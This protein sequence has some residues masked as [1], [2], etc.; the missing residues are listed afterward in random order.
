[1]WDEINKHRIFLMHKFFQVFPTANLDA[2]EDAAI[3]LKEIDEILEFGRQILAHAF[4]GALAAFSV[5]PTKFHECLAFV[6]DH[7]K[8]A[9]AAE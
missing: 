2:N 6:V 8:K 9:K 1:M 7:R 3:R 5:E 4:H